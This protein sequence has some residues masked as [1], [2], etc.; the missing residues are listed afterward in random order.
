MKVAFIIRPN[1]H[2][3]PGGDTVQMNQTAKELQKLGVSV[4]I[5]TSDK[6]IDYSCFDLI[7]FFNI[8]DCEDLLYHALHAKKPIALSSIYVD[9]REY[10]RHHR[11]GVINLLSKIL[12]YHQI[13]YLKTLAKFVLK[14]EKVSTPLYWIKGHNGSIRCILEKTTLLLPNSQNEYS[15]LKNDFNVN[16]PYHVIPNGFDPALFYENKNTQPRKGILCVGRIEGR[17]NQLNLIRAVNKTT[18]NLTLIGQIAPNQKGY[19]KQCLKEAGPNVKFIDYL[20]QHKLLHFYNQSKV[21]AMPSWFETTGLSNLEAAAMG[22]N[23]VIANRGDVMDYFENYAYYCAPDS[24]DSIKEAIES[25]YAAEKN[26]SLKEHVLSNF[27]WEIA[28]A[29]TLKAYI[30]ILKHYDT[31]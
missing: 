17:K 29:K 9:Y 5:F 8:T 3:I 12:P 19:Y 10:D 13:E 6:K 7:H 27:I 1:V 30:E 24:V 25:A 18:Y 21:H 31:I 22:C 11:T 15:R 16:L 28:A 14:R 20:P 2:T 4:D 26:D 23:L